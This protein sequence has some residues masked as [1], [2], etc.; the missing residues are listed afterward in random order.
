MSASVNRSVLLRTTIER[1]P[2]RTRAASGS[3]SVRIRSWSSTKTRRSA[4]AARSRAS[5]SRSEPASPISDRP[6]RVGQ[7]DGP[8]D[9]F[10]RVGVVLGPLGRAHDRAR[11]CRPSTQECVDQRRLAGR[12]GAEDDDVKLAAFLPGL[13]LAQFPVQPGLG[14]LIRDLPDHVPGLLRLDGRGL[15]HVFGRLNRRPFSRAWSSRA[16]GPPRA[17]RPPAARS[18]RQK[19]ET[20]AARLLGEPVVELGRRAQQP[21]SQAQRQQQGRQ[22]QIDGRG[23]RSHACSL[24]ESIRGRWPGPSQVSFGPMVI[25]SRDAQSKIVQ[26]RIVTGSSLVCIKAVMAGPRCDRCRTRCSAIPKSA[27]KAPHGSLAT[28]TRVELLLHPGFGMPPQSL[29]D[30][31][32]SH[33]G[34]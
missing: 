31:P 26:Y 6:G 28:E 13:E 22:R 24:R 19:S 27:I 32:S 25:Y 3:Y 2:W 9:P 12:A 11:S 7:E 17:P 1:L 21:G 33:P 16:A 10:Q 18:R 4:R 23:S 34:C 15:D 5:R 20:Q 29:S 8:L 30:E 14:G